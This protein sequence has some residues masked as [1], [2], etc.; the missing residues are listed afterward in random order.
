[1]VLIEK[2]WCIVLLEGYSQCEVG[3]IVCSVQM[4]MCLK[5]HPIWMSFRTENQVIMFGKSATEEEKNVLIKERERRECSSCLVCRGSKKEERNYE[6]VH[7]RNFVFPFTEYNKDK[8]PVDVAAFLVVNHLNI[9]V[10]YLFEL[11]YA[12][13]H[14]RVT[15]L[16]NT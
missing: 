11:C 5:G 4:N 7:S 15:D 9:G 10:L 13:V 1:M 6:V 3:F 16:E 14:G 12:Y 8:V 2:V